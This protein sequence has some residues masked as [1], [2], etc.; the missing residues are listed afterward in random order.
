MGIKK[1]NIIIMLCIILLN[2]TIIVAY[3]QF[4]LADSLTNVFNRTYKDLKEEVELIAK[5]AQQLGNKNAIQEEFSK[6]KDKTIIL[7]DEQENIIYSNDVIINQNTIINSQELIKLDGK[8]Y[9]LEV[10]KEIKLEELQKTEV[11]LK[12]LKMEIV[13][14]F[15]DVIILG[16]FTHIAYLNP[17]VAIQDSMKKYKKGIF[18]KKSIRGDEFGY[19][20]NTFVDITQSLELEKQKQERIIASISHDVKTPLT[21]IMGYSERL[22]KGI[23]DEQKKK[24]YIDVIYTKAQNIKELVE[25]FDEYLGYKLEKNLKKQVVTVEELCNIIQSDYKDELESQQIEFEIENKCPTSRIEV[26][27]S[28]MR[29]VFANSIGNSVKHFN[30]EE[31]KIKIIVYLKNKKIII[32]IQD[33]GTG[34]KTEELEKIFETLYT[35]DEG[36]KVAGLGLS[37]SKDIIESHGGEIWA[38]N[39]TMGGLSIVMELEKR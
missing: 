29:R 39:N 8:T 34:V 20:Q 9:L 2:V 7:K 19:L 17:I 12:L 24:R 38:Q 16:I 4:Y 6:I 30:K 28:K 15:M 14:L 1:K 10:E 18:P 32:E 13:L 31:K 22:K 27:I 21:S 11:I 25:E 23:E 35:S 33:N 3:Y 5:Q 36:R 26:D 37:I